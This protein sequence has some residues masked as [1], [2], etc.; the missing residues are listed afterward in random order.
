MVSRPHSRPSYLAHARTAGPLGQ[1]TTP[2]FLKRP[3]PEP[4]SDSACSNRIAANIAKL[5]ELL[6]RGNWKMVT[7]LTLL[8]PALSVFDLTIVLIGSI[9]TASAVIV[10]D[11]E[12]IK[13]GSSGIWGLM[14]AIEPYD[15]SLASQDWSQRRIWA[16]RVF[17]ELM[18]TH[19]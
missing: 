19:F 13:A 6:K 14:I 15:F 10:R 4:S 5:P 17:D 8:F 16:E 3:P 11:E 9:I 7:V 18:T 2:K 1:N 12:A